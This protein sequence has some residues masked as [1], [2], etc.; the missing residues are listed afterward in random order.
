[1]KGIHVFVLYFPDIQAIHNTTLKF[2]KEVD[3]SNG[4]TF[5][6]GKSVML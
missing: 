6:Y 5:T 2:G 4:W 3:K 1:M